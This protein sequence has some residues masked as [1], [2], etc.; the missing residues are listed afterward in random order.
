M[1]VFVL[2]LARQFGHGSPRPSFTVSLIKHRCGLGRGRARARNEPRVSRVLT[3]IRAVHNIP[4]SRFRRLFPVCATHVCPFGRLMVNG[5]ISVSRERRIQMPSCRID[6]VS[7]ARTVRER[8]SLSFR[9]TPINLDR[10]RNYVE[11]SFSTRS[12][13]LSRPRGNRDRGNYGIGGSRVLH[14]EFSPGAVSVFVR[15]CAHAS[16]ERI[17]L[18]D[19]EPSRERAYPS[20]CRISKRA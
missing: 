4:I 7:R 9:R 20:Q 19:V 16:Q 8:W 18:L 15:N 13:P 10:G 14:V 3:R 2:A 11:L 5:V 1:S 17:N 6:D 12:P